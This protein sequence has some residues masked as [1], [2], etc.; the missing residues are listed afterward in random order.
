MQITELWIYPVKSFGGFRT[1]DAEVEPWGLCGDRRWGVVDPRGSK[2]TARE[3]PALLG[4][5]AEILDEE[6]IRI[7]HGGAAARDQG[8]EDSILVE[9]P[10]GMPAVP[11]SHSRLGSA[12]P[13]D[14]DVNDWLS[15]RLGRPVRLVWQED[16]RDRT[17][18]PDHGG[19]D[20]ETL[21]LADAGPLL[22]TT[23][24]SLARLQEWV[25]PAPQLDMLRF[26]PNVVIDGDHP[27]AEDD[28]ATVRLGE[29][30]FRTTEVCDRCV[31]TTIDPHT[32]QKG[33]EPIATLARHRAWA[34]KTWFGT[35]LVPLGSG[36]LRVGD[37]VTPGAERA[38][39]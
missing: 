36:T 24:A 3:V 22:L 12:A 11:V 35:R 39:R 31:M 30:E 23:E 10:I 21:S 9:A 37:D 38:D 20:G 34:G 7:H 26:R 29:V 14:E 17:L 19:R 27:F 33:K 16:P 8:S 1:Q 32:L 15:T 2:L 5:R 28:W 4:L 18:D 25:G 13:A 6:T